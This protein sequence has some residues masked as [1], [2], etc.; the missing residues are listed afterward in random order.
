MP[1]PPACL[2]VVTHPDL[3]ANLAAGAFFPSLLP[4]CCPQVQRASRELSE[5]Q[6]DLTLARSRAEGAVKAADASQ[7]DGAQKLQKLDEEVGA[8]RAACGIVMSS[9]CRGRVGDAGDG[10]AIEVPCRWA[11]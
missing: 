10:L 1:C 2:P 9:C 11:V 3:V 8:G 5:A 6:R 7:V 4:L